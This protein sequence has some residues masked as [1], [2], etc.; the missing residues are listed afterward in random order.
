MVTI[1]PP[2]RRTVRVH[3]VG[4]PGRAPMVEVWAAMSAQ[5]AWQGP[6][7]RVIRHS[8]RPAAPAP[9][10]IGRGAEARHHAERL[11]R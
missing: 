10:M 1:L 6:S 5:L 4:V 3:L 2:L 9:S 11:Q 8:E 7:P